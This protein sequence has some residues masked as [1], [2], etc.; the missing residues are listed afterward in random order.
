MRIAAVSKPTLGIVAANCFAPKTHA[1]KLQ[2]A[3]PAHVVQRITA[4]A[5]L[6]ARIRAWFSKSRY[7]HDAPFW[8]LHIFINRVAAACGK[9]G[10]TCLAGKPLDRFRLKAALRT[11][12]AKIHSLSRT[13]VSRATVPA[14]EAAG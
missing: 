9:P 4:V 1:I 10:R 13:N 8:M 14:T 11:P 6:A 3:T 12:F 2:D 7:Q 5:A